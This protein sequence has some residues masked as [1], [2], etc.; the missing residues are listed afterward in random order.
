[1]PFSNWDLSQIHTSTLC[2]FTA[3]V[4]ITCYSTSSPRRIYWGLYKH[5]HSPSSQKDPWLFYLL[6]RCYRSF[7]WPVCLYHANKG[8]TT[9]RWMLMSMKSQPFL[10]SDTWSWRFGQT[11][12]WIGV[13]LSFSLFFLSACVFLSQFYISMLGVMS[14]EYNRPSFSVP[15]SRKKAMSQIF[16][17]LKREYLTGKTERCRGAVLFFSCLFTV[18]VKIIQLR[19]DWSNLQ[20]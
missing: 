2:H 10:F 16:N 3:A 13:S 12:L 5:T 11:W 7:R 17:E 8:R 14:D 6:L 4:I 19:W 1:M 15:R 18:A 9:G 20:K